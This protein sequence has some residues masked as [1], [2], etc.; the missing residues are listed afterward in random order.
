[1]VLLNGP[2]LHDTLLLVIPSLYLFLCLIFA[3]SVIFVLVTH[4]RPP[5]VTQSK[6]G[7]LVVASSSASQGR[8]KNYLFLLFFILLLFFF[9]SVFFEQFQKIKNLFFF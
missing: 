5:G 6:S 4:P 8:E 2:Y 1:M 7:D 3:F 9:C